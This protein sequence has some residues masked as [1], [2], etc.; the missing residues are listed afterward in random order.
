MASKR[1]TIAPKH[2]G[3]KW[4]LLYVS[5]FFVIFGIFGLLPILFTVYVSF[6]HWDPLAGHNFIGLENFRNLF[7][8][9]YFYRAVRNTFS[10]F[11]IS[12]LP[13]TVLA[14]LLANF[15]A[16]PHL[17]GKVFWRTVLLVP[18]VTS[19]LSVAIIFSELFG[20]NYGMVNVA[21]RYLGLSHLGI[22]NINWVGQTIPSHIAIAS[23]IIY[24]NLGYASLIYL[25]SML[26]I[27]RDLYESASLDGAS[28]LQQFR[29]VT[30]P[31]LKNTLTFMLIVGTIGGLQTFL[32]PLTYGGVQGGDSRQFSTLALYLYE[33]IIINNKLG[34]A[35]AIGVAITILTVIISGVN[36]FVTRRISGSDS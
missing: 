34:Y 16:N 14:L 30:I 5:P 31:Q 6:F 1:S 23:M 27:P 8:D 35:A 33:Q 20:Q 32:E 11:L 36:F 19:I 9:P 17:K 15:L 4:G 12:F 13:Q 25:A 26:A 29:Y 2:K 22:H 21:M 28:K 7:T 18:W 10:I 3:D 24:R